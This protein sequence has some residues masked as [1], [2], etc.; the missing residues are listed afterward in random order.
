MFLRL[1]SK[2]KVSLLKYTMEQIKQSKL[3]EPGT[4]NFGNEDIIQGL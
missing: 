3:T 1:Y 2:V 4:D